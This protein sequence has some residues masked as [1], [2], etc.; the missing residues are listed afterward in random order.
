MR[1]E[2]GPVPAA[3][4]RWLPEYEPDASGVGVNYAD[5]VLKLFKKN[6]EDG[7]KISA[8][9][10]GLRITLQIGDRSG[11]AL[12]RRREDGPDVREILHGALERA[13]TEAGARFEIDDGA[14]VLTLV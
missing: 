5:A 3:A 8:R 12:L 13:A 1:I 2:L 11:Q 7:R 14:V 6:L 10:R 4:N 9:R